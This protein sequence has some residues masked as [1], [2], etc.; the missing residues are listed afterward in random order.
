MYYC[1]F[2]AMARNLCDCGLVC[3]YI[4]KTHI[5][6][7][8]S[9]EELVELLSE[10]T[11]APV[12]LGIH[13]HESVFNIPAWT[14]FA[15]STCAIFGQKFN[16]A[17]R[18]IPLYFLIGNIIFYPWKDKSLIQ[19]QM[20]LSDFIRVKSTNKKSNTIERYHQKCRVLMS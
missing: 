12:I 14:L 13:P 1:I 5:M 9:P 18:M 2:F 17:D 6:T 8:F 20:M 19:T 16:Y 4:T 10:Y 3:A 11:T 7:C 15:T